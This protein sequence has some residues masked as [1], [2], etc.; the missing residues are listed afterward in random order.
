MDSNVSQIKPSTNSIKLYL[1]VRISSGRRWFDEKCDEPEEGLALSEEQERAW[2]TYLSRAIFKV[3]W[4]GLLG[5][6]V[7][8]QTLFL[9][10]GII[11]VG[12]LRT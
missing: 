3:N 8:K 10:L 2:M 4:Q 9:I 1:D 5:K 11:L 7:T 12:L 6:V